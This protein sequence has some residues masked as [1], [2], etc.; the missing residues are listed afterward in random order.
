[1]PLP[2]AQEIRVR[3]HSFHIKHDYQLEDM[4]VSHNRKRIEWQKRGGDLEKATQ[5]PDAIRQELIEQ[6]PWMTDAEVEDELFVEQTKAIQK[7]QRLIDIVESLGIEINARAQGKVNRVP[8][9]TTY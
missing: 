1:M 7:D 2:P 4:L 6:F 9:G 5:R 8:I 3:K